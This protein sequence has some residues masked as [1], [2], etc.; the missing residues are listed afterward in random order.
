MLLVILSF[1]CFLHNSM[2]LYVLGAFSNYAAVSIDW[3]EIHQIHSVCLNSWPVLYISLLWDLYNHINFILISLF[4]ASGHRPADGSTHSGGG[5]FH[6]GRGPL[7]VHNSWTDQSAGQSSFTHQNQQHVH[8]SVS[9]NPDSYRE[10]VPT[11]EF[12]P[13]HSRDSKLHAAKEKKTLRDLVPPLCAARLKPIRQK[14]KNALVRFCLYFHI[15][16]QLFEMFP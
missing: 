15:I 3:K 13:P 16:F 11:S 10:N 5:S 8:H 12:P 4:S 7:V 14:T 9:S 1:N 2:R 6:S